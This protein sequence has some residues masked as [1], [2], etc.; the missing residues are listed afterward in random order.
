MPSTIKRKSISKALR[1]QV[2]SRDGFACRYCGARRDDGAELHIDHVKPVSA[3]GTNDI[4]NLVTSCQP[5][6]IGKGAVEIPDPVPFQLVRVEKGEAA[7]GLNFDE[8]GELQKQ[9]HIDALSNMVAKVTLY[10]WITG[11]PTDQ[12][13]WLIEVIRSSC[14]LFSD[15]DEWLRCASYWGS[16]CD[17]GQFNPRFRSEARE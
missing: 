8:R 2:L 10:S 9:F 14:L 12:E 1:F 7:F 17:R 3:G 5:C 16:M 15:R 4:G 11:D 6:N 13:T